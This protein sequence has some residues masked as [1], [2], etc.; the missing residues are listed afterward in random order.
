MQSRPSSWSCFEINEYHKQLNQL[1]QS[2][3]G[4]G[5]PEAAKGVFLS[6]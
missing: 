5:L 4:G 1:F 2:K 3:I 6:S